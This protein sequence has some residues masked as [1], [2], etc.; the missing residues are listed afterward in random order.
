MKQTKFVL[1]ALMLFGAHFSANAQRKKVAVVTFYCDKWIDMSGIG[2]DAAML[3][4]V[5]TLAEDPAFDIK[6]VL[7]KFHDVFFN[8]YAKQFPFDLL[9]ESE[10]IG[11][12][13]YKT[14]E[15]FWDETAD[16]DRNKLMQRYAT[17]DGYKPL[18]E[19]WSKSEKR[20][21]KR[22]LE[23]FGD[24]VDGVMFV[25]LDFSMVQKIAVGGTGAAGVNAFCRMKVWNKKGDK[26]FTVNE[27]AKSK[28]T[29]AVVGGIPIMKPEKVL[30]LCEDSA[31]QLIEDLRKRLNKIATKA[32]EKL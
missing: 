23:I 29:V 1:I 32:A 31:D 8:E 2:S 15:S 28:G 27:N 13:S 6:K 9:P 4:S 24:K 7:T 19:M 26:V 30:P 21:E 18:L 14:Y 22:M 12:E 5:A 25:Y 10:V 20:N 11:N 3:S 16:K 17:V